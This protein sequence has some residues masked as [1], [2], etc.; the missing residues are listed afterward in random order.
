MSP[1]LPSVVLRLHLI[2][3]FLYVTKNRNKIFHS[4][5]FHSILNAL[6]TREAKFRFPKN[7]TLCW[8]SFGKNLTLFWGLFG[9]FFQNLFKNWR[10]KHKLNSRSLSKALKGINFP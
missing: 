4:I 5:Q 1:Q 8:L 2:E 3:T 7:L 10:E 6:A 9:D